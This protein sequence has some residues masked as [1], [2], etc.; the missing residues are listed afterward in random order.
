MDPIDNG[1]GDTEQLTLLGVRG[2]VRRSYCFMSGSSAKLWPVDAII[3]PNLAIPPCRWL[4]EVII[5][6]CK[7]GQALSDEDYNQPQHWDLIA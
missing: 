5:N 6:Q 3:N 7:G 1:V 4:C 2:V